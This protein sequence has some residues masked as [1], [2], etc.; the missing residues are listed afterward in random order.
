MSLDLNL[1]NVSLDNETFKPML[2]N[3]QANIL[4]S[5][6]RD[7]AYH[8]F[9]VIEPSRIQQAKIWIKYFT[10]SGR[11]TSAIAQLSGTR[12]FKNGEISDAGTIRTLSISASGY[13]K[14]LGE[15]NLPQDEFF[16]A[17]MKSH[18]GLGDNHGDW[19]VAFKENLDLFILVASDDPIEASNES[20]AIIQEVID[21]ATATVIQRGNVLKMK[22][23]P[24]IEH[25][26]YADGISQ[27]IYLSEEIAQQQGNSEWHDEH[28]LKF[29]LVPDNVE[30]SDSFG[31]YLVFRKLEQ[32][33]EGFKDSEKKLPA[34]ATVD[35]KANSEL[36]GALIVGRFENGMTT[37]KGST[38][39]M[40]N[41]PRN[42]NDFDHSDDRDAL[43]C[44]FHAHT[45][46]M[47]PRNGDKLAGNVSA[48]RITRR[49]MPYDD[50]QRFAD[51]QIT[52]I[53]EQMLDVSFP[54]EKVGLL[55]MCY[56]SSIASQFRILQEFWANEGNI[57]PH[58]IGMQDSLISQGS[59]PEKTLPLQWNKQALSSP[60]KFGH[61]VTTKGGEYF[62]TPSIPFL[63]TL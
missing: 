42:D 10:S 22:N 43:K 55:F 56:Q 1:S 7:F 46:I 15:E 8:M 61:F 37:A 2:S 50:I 62:F 4:K 28:Q 9:F 39:T 19:D 16:Q 51:D 23:G 5:H 31:S 57:N 21:F 63:K 49:G 45:R 11:I 25:F 53:T 17:G 35:G 40:P 6:G 41:P 54:R 38:D 52:Q 30:E 36:A 60:F 59:N 32:N 27:P 12:R 14:L 24:G 26:G 18:Q 34:V 20:D 3:L 33:V 13:R 29:L 44:P 47:N 48:I 58:K